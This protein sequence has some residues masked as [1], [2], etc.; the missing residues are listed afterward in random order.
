MT[1]A[2]YATVAGKPVSALRIVVC[3]TGPWYAEADMPDDSPLGDGPI[4]ITIGTLTLIGT[5][6]AGGAFALQR[7]VRIVAG[8]D[9]W[10]DPIKAV[11][12]HNDAGVKA[13][14][15]AEDAARAVG[16]TIGDFVPAAERLGV[17][18]ARQMTVASRALEDAVGDS[19]AW[20][21]DYA[22]VTQAGPRPT[23]ALSDDVYEVLA[24]DPREQM[25]TLHVDDPAV[26]SIGVIISKRIETP[27]PVREYE[28]RW[29]ESELRVIA[30]L[31]GTEGGRG[32]LANLMQAIVRHAND[33]ALW[34]VYRYRVVAM[35]ADGRAT[36]QAVRKAAAV[37]DLTLIS[38]WPGIPG[39]TAVL[40]S[41][42][43]VLVAFVE[44]DRAQPV[45][46]HYTGPGGMGFVPVQLTLGGTTGAP[47]AR[48]G[49]TVEV[50]LGPAV[51]VGTLSGTTPFTGVITFP[52]A[53]AL[54]TI[55]AGSS[56]VRVAT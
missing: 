3:N 5:M 45:I 47:A 24:Y 13:R 42:A 19:V 49:D 26:I 30:W 54:G 23:A 2:F 37:P 43:E 41:G 20:W 48:S 53:N 34:G 14:L 32:K 33:Q 10:S 27:A 25:A 36:L 35:A 4:T 28:I 52:N 18:Y 7:T 39:A 9:G 29:Q 46:T 55:T 1:A 50:L 51:I 40:T 17:D 11:G 16:E 38:Q 21:V 12:Y 6:R 8:A 31:G 22:G 15:V 56:K 44:G